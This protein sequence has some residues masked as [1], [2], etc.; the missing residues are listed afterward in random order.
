MKPSC[1]DDVDMTLIQTFPPHSNE[2]GR[3]YYRRLSSAN[4]M[5]SWKELTRHVG[6]RC[7]FDALLAHPEPVAQTLGIDP[8][9]C[10]Q[11]SAQDDR[12]RGWTGLRRH[13]R[14][15]V[16][17]HC[18]RESV[19]L[20]AIWEHAYLVACPAHGVLMRD[21]CPS[22]SSPLHTGREH[23]EFCECGFDL[24]ML[25]SEPASVAQT[26]VSSLVANGAAVLD[27]CGPA[28]HDVPAG[29]AAKL[30]NI[31]CKQP[32]PTVDARRWNASAPSTVL[33]LVA[34]L[35][36]LEQLLSNWPLNFKAHV[37]VR[38]RAGHTNGRTLNSRLGTWY[39]QL[40]K[41]VAHE[42]SHPF[43]SAVGQVAEAE[44]DGVLGL[45]AAAAVITKEA[46]HVLL[47]E[48]AKRIGISHSAL[49]QH[50]LN[51]NLL[52]KE[53]KSGTNGRVYQVAVSE[54]DDIIRARTMWTTEEEACARL[55]VLPSVLGHLCDAGAILRDARWSK[56]L[57]K[58]GPIAV[59]S[60]TQF[61]EQLHRSASRPI[62]GGRRVALQNLS[63]RRVGDKKALASALQA[64]SAGHIGAVKA[65]GL[66][67]SYEFEWDQIAQHYARP[68]LDQGLSIQA[69]SEATGYKHES[70]SSWVAHGLLKSR[71]VLLRGQPARI[72][73]PTQFAEFRRKYVPLSDLAKALNTK[74]SALARQLGNI[75]LV[76]HQVLPGG[77][78]RGGVVR[79]EDLARAAFLHQPNTSHPKQ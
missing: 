54:V 75:E 76:G 18:L 11:A 64:I 58:G 63:A 31:L 30:I 62:S 20:R 57:R 65:E 38:L 34:F 19:H 68:L 3:G 9:W 72:V 17:G 16:C 15:A 69:L 28:M 44:F 56:D 32:D 60:V 2:S 10:Q 23:I 53:I 13:G 29:V 24:R 77:Q 21:A 67:G 22:C 26:W 79:M 59:H 43:L 1:H 36:P 50:R 70:V 73:T 49:T 45:D 4:A 42:A 37:S 39:Q 61:I 6:A 78:R 12:V 71:E 40:R 55:G 7:T 5:S 66:V 74:S 35:Q 51:G 14:D 47:L 52:C 25:E 27:D 41:L 46:T 33:Q 8:A 48:A